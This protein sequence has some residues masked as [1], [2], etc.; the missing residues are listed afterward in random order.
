MAVVV[1]AGL[2]GCSGDDGSGGGSTKPG[3]DASGDASDAGTDASDGALP[4]A[5]TS[6]VA[7]DV[8]SDAMNDA[9]G[10][11]APDAPPATPSIH[12]VGRNEALPSGGARFGWPGTGFVVRFQGTGARV[13]MDDPSGYF[14][15]VVDGQEQPRLETTSGE[16]TYELASGL[17]AGEHTVEVYRRAE[18]FFGATTVAAIE[19]DGTLS[20][21]PV[22]GRRIE[23]LGDS[24]SCGYG[25]EGADQNC[26]FSADTENHYR[27][28]GA[29]A[30]RS[31]G[32]ELSTIAWSGKGVIYNYGDDTDEPLPTLF[33]RTIPS[34]SSGVW[35]FGWQPDAVLINL[36]T[37]DFST[38]NDPTESQFTGAYV[39][40]LEDLRNAYPNALLLCTVAPL[41]SGAEQTLVMG[42]IQQAVDTRSTSGDT[43]VKVI[44]LSTD[45]VGWGCD[46]HPSIATHEAM[47]ALFTTALKSELGW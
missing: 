31:V 30:A 5:P 42:Y 36:G 22:S 37:N 27:T 46:W 6:D 24:I 38:D 3:A 12:Y 21:P 1:V 29:V 7:S 25:N 16:Q 26:N 18:G 47:A 43:K 9:V 4:D 39:A 41:L 20:A 10:E 15:V 40:L 33:G 13:R 45:A 23:I 44:D 8:T 14:T 28:Y 32:A 19:L 34:E 2:I 11:A 35:D 17:P